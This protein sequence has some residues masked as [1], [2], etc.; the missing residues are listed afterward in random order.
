M[1]P[2]LARGALLPRKILPRD[3]REGVYRGGGEP[4]RLYHRI[5]YG[6]DGTP[7]P[8]IEG[9]VA[10][11]DI[12]HLVNFVRSQAEPAALIEEESVPQS[13]SEQPTRSCPSESL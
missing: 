2:L 10:P 1:I 4:E 12:W 11:E 7:M 6:I 13:A 3:L 8:A 5:A 9:V